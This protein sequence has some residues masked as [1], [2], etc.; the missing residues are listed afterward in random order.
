M[1]DDDEYLILKQF[2]QDLIILAEKENIQIS[3]RKHDDTIE[4]TSSD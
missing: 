4:A 3:I 1:M 2:I